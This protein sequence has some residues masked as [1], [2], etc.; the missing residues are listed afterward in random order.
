MLD[1]GASINVMPLSIFK[2]LSLGPLQPTVF[3]LANMSVAHPTD[4]VEDVLVRVGKL[5]FLADFYVLDMEDGFSHGSSPIILGRPFLKTAR[6]KVDVYAGTLS[7]EFGDIVV[8]FNILDAMK[9]PY[10]DHSYSIFHAELI[11]DLVDEHILDFY[12]FHDKNHSFLSDLYNYFHALN[13]N[14]NLE[15]ILIVMM[16]MDLILWVLYILIL[17]L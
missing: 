5:I 4:F 13:L 14:L 3:Q 2:S 11:D 9:F 12:S 1:L 17:I 7:M 16:H 8:H 10:E 15:V 6:T